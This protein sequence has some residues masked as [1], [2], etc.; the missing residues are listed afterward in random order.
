[1]VKKIQEYLT[2]PKLNKND[3]FI[4]GCNQ[5]GKCCRNREDVLLTPLDLF[6]ISKHLKMQISEVLEKYCETYKGENSKM[7]I[8]RIKPKAY[9]QT[10]PFLK[11]GICLIQPAK[12]AVCALFPLG[13]M[14]NFETNEF[15]YFLQST[16]CGNQNQEQTVRDWLGEFNIADDEHITTLWHHKKGEMS[17]ILKKV[18]ERFNLNHNDINAILLLTL[19]VM[20]DLERDFMPQFERNLEE[21]FKFVK[22]IA[23]VKGVALNG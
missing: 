20:Y 15:V 8:V 13:R 6:K 23:S 19:Y 5:C 22:S 17:L 7:P 1:M 16:T 21:A 14:T 11:K 12:P 2:L 18:Y 3:T 4:F 9:Q 10:C